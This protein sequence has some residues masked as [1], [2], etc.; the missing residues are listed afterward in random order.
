MNFF[1]LDEKEKRN[2]KGKD[3]LLGIVKGNVCCSYV[4][5]GSQRQGPLGESRVGMTRLNCA[6]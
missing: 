1:S 6:M 4:G 5:E 2:R 3:S